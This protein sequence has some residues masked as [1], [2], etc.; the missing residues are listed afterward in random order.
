MR[1]ERKYLSLEEWRAGGDFI[2]TTREVCIG[3]GVVY[4]PLRSWHANIPAGEGVSSIRGDGSGCLHHN[5]SGYPDELPEGCTLVPG[6]KGGQ[7]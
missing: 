2:P 7:G 5:D 1:D 4:R 6:V 3:A